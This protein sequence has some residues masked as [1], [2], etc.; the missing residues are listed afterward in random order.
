[1]KSIQNIKVRQLVDWKAALIAGLAGGLVS[2]TA[3]I[4]L[5]SLLLDSPWLLVRIISS[6]LMGKGVLPP[7]AGFNWSIF[8]TSLFIHLL[9]SVIFSALIAIVVHQWG[10]IISFIGGALMGLA[11]YAIAFYTFSMFYPW[12]FTFRNWIFLVMYILY[13]AFTGSVYELLEVEKYGEIKE[14]GV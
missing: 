4:F 10:I 6:L 1:M 8:L 2:L 5:S 9:L 11:F 13:G 14:G 3:N 12:F 7:P